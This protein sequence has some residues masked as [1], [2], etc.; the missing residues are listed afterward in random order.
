MKG[1]GERP[2][3]EAAEGRAPTEAL[4]ALVRLNSAETIGLRQAE[5]LLE[6]FGSYEAAFRQPGAALRE[7]PGIGPRTAELLTDP[8]GEERA[9]AEI[10]RA[11]TEGIR[12]LAHCDPGYPERLRSIHNPPLVLYVRGDP[13][14]LETALALGIVGTRRPTVYG[15]LQ[16][17]RFGRELAELGFLV[18]SGLARGID[19]EAHA[20]ALE[21]KGKT[22]AFLGSGLLRPYPPEH[23]RLAERIAASGGAAVSE[24]ALEARPLT[25]HF[26]RRNR[27]ISGLSLGVLVVEAPLKS[28]SIITATH[29]HEQG[30]E[31]F[32]IPG[33]IDF[34]ACR[35]TH[36]LL[37]DGAKLVEGVEDILE[38]LSPEAKAVLR[39]SG[40][41]PEGD[42]A[43][44]SK[45]EKEFLKLI[46]PAG[47]H[48]DEL[49]TASGRTPEAVTAMLTR[50]ELKRR[51]RRHPGMVFSRTDPK[52]P[53]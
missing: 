25:H 53:S 48:A 44:L 24:F 51:V 26:P 16:A 7:L 49:V 3:R 11:E 9:E 33:R 5:A 4:R 37:R 52:K 41:E 8:A 38:E 2:R 50:L 46:D 20:G 13:A 36:R 14:V 15:R 29:A 28:G 45:E 22:A 27:L 10:R 19:G 35:G 6:R 32:A 12:I 47:T 23:A 39:A 21:A 18:V 40:T 43:G 1:A 17:R 34:P 42:E 31:V 30:R